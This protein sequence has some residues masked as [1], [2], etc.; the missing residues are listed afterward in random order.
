MN[1][2]VEAIYLGTVRHTRLRPVEHRLRYRV[3]SLMFDCDMLQTINGRFR[4]LS[5]NRPNLFS[6]Q[7]ADHGEGRP[8]RD[9]L[10]DL[11]S[12]AGCGG[13]V[14]RFMMLC[15][16]RVLGYVFN[17]LTV[18][19]GFDGNDRLRLLIHEVNNTFGQRATYVL[20]V[21]DGQQRTIAQA[22]EKRLYVSPFNGA[23]GQYSFRVTPP[24]D[25]LTLGVALRDGEGPVLKAL[26]TGERRPLS[27]RELLKALGRTGWLTAKVTAGIHLE[28]ARLWLKGLRPR[29]RPVAAARSVHFGKACKEGRPRA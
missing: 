16:P 13:D 26:F 25:R 24:D 28:A 5:Y 10:P 20:P 27:D 18:Y 19:Y 1:R 4:L 6:L 29:A 17:P 7:D 3:F 8:L 14:V 9:Y 12:R 22:H 23:S 21:A 2:A 15:F 11:A